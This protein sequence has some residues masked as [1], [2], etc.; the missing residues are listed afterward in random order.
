MKNLNQLAKRIHKENRNW[1]ID[2]NT[3]KPLQRNPGEC[4]MLVVTEL[5]E[6]V[7]GIRKDL[8]DDTLPHRKMEEVE[9]ADAYIRLLDYV[10][11]SG[12]KLSYG[13]AVPADCYWLHEGR[14]ETILEITAQVCRCRLSVTSPTHGWPVTLALAMIE[15]YCEHFGLDLDG[16][17]EEKLAYNAKR[18]DHTLEARRKAGGKKF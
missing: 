16:A 13:R 11:G 15:R 18:K 1:W 4:L 3:G 8:M 9:M 17:M 5:S 10:G 12:V 2:L 6:A 14:S 7:E